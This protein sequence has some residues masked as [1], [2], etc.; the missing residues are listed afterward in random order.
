MK[1]DFKRFE[2]KIKIFEVESGHEYIITK[3]EYEKLLV[4]KQINK[5]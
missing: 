1:K 2:C 4:N 5:L 3:R